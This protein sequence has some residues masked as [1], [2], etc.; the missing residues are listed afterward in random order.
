MAQSVKLGP[1]SDPGANPNQ[2]AQAGKSRSQSARGS[3]RQSLEPR[4]LAM[5]GGAV[6][7]LAVVALLWWIFFGGRAPE[8][9]PLSFP[10]G[11]AGPPI[12]G[13][14]GAGSAV[15]GRKPGG[16]GLNGPQIPGPPVR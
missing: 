12:P 15:P 10:G 11:T 6:G 1:S 9:K 13:P 8:A 4:V 14:P 3:A 7:L 16:M 5:A 2:K